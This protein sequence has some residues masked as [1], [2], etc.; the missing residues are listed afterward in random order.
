MNIEILRYP[1]LEDWKRCKELALNTIGVKYT[2]KEIIDEWK[3]RLLMAEHSPIRTLMFTIKMEIPYYVSTHFV[4][5]KIGVEH[6]VQSQRNDRQNKYNRNEAPQNSIV[7]HIMDINAQGIINI[8]HKRLCNQ[9]DKETIKVM[10][11]IKRKIIETN[12][13][14]ECVLIPMCEYKNN[15]CD[16]FYSCGRINK[17]IN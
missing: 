17:G 15:W 2:G 13:E 12:P 14:F 9:A 16:E 4:R 3:I 11:E 6:F 8:A 1:T 7:S 10:Q 5:H